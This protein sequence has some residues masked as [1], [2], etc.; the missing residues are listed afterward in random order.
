MAT[1]TPASGKARG[2]MGPLQRLMYFFTVLAL[3]RAAE[4]RNERS[5]AKDQVDITDPKALLRHAEAAARDRDKA[6]QRLLNLPDLDELNPKDL[7]LALTD[8][9]T[10]RDESPA[11]RDALDKIIAFMGD[12]HG[13]TISANA[14]TVETD[15]DFEA[16]S[17]QRR[18]EKT[19]ATM[20]EQAAVSAASTLITTSGLAPDDQ[21]DVTAV[22]SEWAD[23]A[24]KQQPDP[25]A[26]PGL[27][28]DA[29]RESLET[30]LAQTALPAAQQAGVLMVVDYLTGRAAEPDRPSV[31]LLTTP[32]FAPPVAPS[33]PGSGPAGPVPPNGA[34]PG[35]ATAP[36]LAPGQPAGGLQQAPR[37][38]GP[39]G[40]AAAPAPNPAASQSYPAAPAGTGP[41]SGPTGTPP[42]STGAQGAPSTGSPAQGRRGGRQ[43]REDPPAQQSAPTQAPGGQAPA[44]TATAGVPPGQGTVPVPPVG[45]ASAAAPPPLPVPPNGQPAPNGA[46]T[47]SPSP[48]VVPEQVDRDELTHKL[49]DYSDTV[50]KALQMAD[51]VATDP[52]TTITAEMYWVADSIQEQRAEL[53]HIA[54]TGHGL[55]NVERTQ[56]RAVI[57]DIDMGKT[58]LPALLW[59]GENYKSAADRELQLHR[60]AEI[61]DRTVTQV[62]AALD[63]AGALDNPKNPDLRRF[64][65]DTV[66]DAVSELAATLVDPPEDYD[67]FKTEFRDAASGLEAALANANVVEADRE[68][69]N[70]FLFADAQSSP[71]Y[72]DRPDRVVNKIVGLLEHT[73]AVTDTK[74][75][76]RPT[77]EHVKQ[78]MD[79]VRT[80]MQAVAA[81]TGAPERREKAF[82]SASNKFGQALKQAGIDPATRKVVDSIL[83]DQGGTAAAH[84]RSSRDRVLEWADRGAVTPVATAK[85]AAQQRKRRPSATKHGTQPTSSPRSTYSSTQRRKQVFTA[86]R[87]AATA[88]KASGRAGRRQ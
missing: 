71:H 67:Q 16:E 54:A 58:E 78:A 52:T 4:R 8:A 44:H 55:L 70:N 87:T 25:D 64:T 62:T 3:R 37:A 30:R 19:A 24:N 76:A 82:L 18:S 10:Y 81:E 7:A 21:Q 68:A 14:A 47:Q 51:T 59:L 41:A 53:L 6:V 83:T 9:A 42:T 20:R 65:D 34:A 74:P 15:P 56:I 11:A 49:S 26:D 85:T 63:E 73:D 80:A 66:R 60:G 69:V 79:G 46:G 2:P 32:V 12:R 39:A 17:W 48:G 29:R 22:L 45:P 57:D 50:R 27:V 86:G 35:P 43:N 33:S 77:P 13:L 61:A 23:S 75:P 40:P 5:K 88:T 72:E 38:A 1:A 28:S 84:A 36:N 31:D